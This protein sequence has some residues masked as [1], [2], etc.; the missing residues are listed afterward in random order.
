[1]NKT[2]NSVNISIR[3]EPQEKFLLDMLARNQNRSLTK[4]LLTAARQMAAL[5]TYGAS[6]GQEH[7]FQP[8]IEQAWSPYPGTRLVLTANHLPTL[9]DF[10]ESRLWETIKRS[11]MF[12]RDTHYGLP[13]ETTLDN[14]DQDALDL[15]WEA[16][17]EH[18]NRHGN[19]PTPTPF[20]S[21][22]DSCVA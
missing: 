7:P 22:S 3:M 4:V 18:V 15:H 5:E 6:T 19:R 9:L 14:L 13:T 20:V 11:A 16:L 8:L 2:K 10:E 12:W 17:L 21:G 1:M